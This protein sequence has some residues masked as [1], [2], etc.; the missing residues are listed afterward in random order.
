LESRITPRVVTLSVVGKTED[1]IKTSWMTG[2]DCK[3]RDEPRRVASD[4]M[5][6]R[7]M[8]LQQNHACIPL[9]ACILVWVPIVSKLTHV[10]AEI[11]RIDIKFTVVIEVS[12]VLTTTS[13]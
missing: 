10:S 9:T 4:F 5:G 8:P 7:H 1:A 6:L 12:S 3:H 11:M 13:E 2:N